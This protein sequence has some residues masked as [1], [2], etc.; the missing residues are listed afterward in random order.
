MSEED[1]NKINIIDTDII[2][3]D[4]KQ[5]GILDKSSPL[6]LPAGSVR[7][8]IALIIT[9]GFL[10]FLF[11]FPNNPIPQ[12]LNNVILLVLGFYFGQKVSTK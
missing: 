9:I 7:S 4:G 12:E 2:D 11:V 6:F 3:T 1:K 8:L 10:G 5:N